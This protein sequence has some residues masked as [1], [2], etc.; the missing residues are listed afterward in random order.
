MKNTR[1]NP[2]LTSFDDIFWQSFL[3][4]WVGWKGVPVFHQ[5]LFNLTYRAS[6]LQ[7]HCAFILE[8]WGIANVCPFCP[9]STVIH[10]LQ[11]SRPLRVFSPRH[12]HMIKVTNRGWQKLPSYGKSAFV[13]LIVPGPFVVCFFWCVAFVLRD[14]F[15]K[16]SGATRTWAQ[17]C[18]AV[19]AQPAIDL[20]RYDTF[21]LRVVGVGVIEMAPPPPSPPISVV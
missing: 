9:V 12:L 14:M 20:T 13:P 7:N 6:T 1:Q 18:R 15:W 17:L 3:K 2:I 5:S 16:R 10:Q 11:T 19:R 4:F 21:P 8:V